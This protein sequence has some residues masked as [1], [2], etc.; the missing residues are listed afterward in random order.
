MIRRFARPYA[1]AM[2]EITVTPERAEAVHAEVSRFEKTRS[3]S[4][5]L[6]DLL[7][8][9]AT[10]AGAKRGVVAEIG[11]RLE[12]SELALKFLDV[13]VGNHRINDLGS[14][15]EAWG[16]L[17]NEATGVVVAEVRSAEALDD[18]AE[19]RLS[20][21]LGKRLGRRVRIEARTDP[22]LLG[23]FVAK[24]GSEIYDASVVGRIKKIR[25]AIS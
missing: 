15:L 8:N 19:K 25:Q 20:G 1:K 14:I 5:E 13:L 12:L 21:V 22:S 3:G 4:R 2:M 23:G 17:I 6:A 24:I 18:E 10:D 9:P 11:R 16:A 7:D